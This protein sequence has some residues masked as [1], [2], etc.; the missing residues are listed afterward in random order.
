MKQSGSIL[1]T[2]GFAFL[3]AAP[4]SYA[5]TVRGHLLDH[6]DFFWTGHLPLLISNGYL[7]R[8]F[9]SVSSSLTAGPWLELMKTD[10]KY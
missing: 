5:Q 9:N 1:I 8:A 10:L 3:V 6:C 2:A 7:L 4:A